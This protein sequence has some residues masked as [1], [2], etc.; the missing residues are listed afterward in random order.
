MTTGDQEFI[1]TVQRR[2]LKMGMLLN[3]FGLWKWTQKSSSEPSSELTP[4]TP[5]G[6]WR[7]MTASESEEAI[8][9]ELGMEVVSPLRRNYSHLLQQDKN[10]FRKS[11]LG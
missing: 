5:L 8:F 7:F 9:A 3:E 4:G 1:R 6:H 2:A 11:W 10:A